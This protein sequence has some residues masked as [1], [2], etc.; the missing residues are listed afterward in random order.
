MDSLLATLA[1]V[2][3]LNIVIPLRDSRDGSLQDAIRIPS[4]A[5]ISAQITPVKVDLEKNLRQLLGV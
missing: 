5:G 3:D 4:W 1:G 2:R